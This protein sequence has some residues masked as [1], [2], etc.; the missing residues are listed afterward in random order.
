M[1]KPAFVFDGRNLLDHKALREIGFYVYGIGK[2]QPLKPQTAQGK[3]MAVAEH[4]RLSGRILVGAAPKETDE[5][6]AL[7]R[8]G[9]PSQTPPPPNVQLEKSGT[10]GGMA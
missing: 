7:K 8:E 5:L 4:N 10:L 2:P 1:Q 6:V 9:T 3:A